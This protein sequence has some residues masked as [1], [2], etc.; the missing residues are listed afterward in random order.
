MPGVW[1]RVKNKRQTKEICL[2]R[3]PLTHVVALC[4]FFFF[5]SS[6]SPVSEALGED[7]SP[8]MVNEVRV[9]I[10]TYLFSHMPSYREQIAQL[11]M[12]SF[13][14]AR[15][16][17]SILSIFASLYL[18]SSMIPY[19]FKF[20]YQEEASSSPVYPCPKV[21]TLLRIWE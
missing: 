20:C 16:P 13:S 6:F 2:S 8:G 19:I 4:N 11:Y 14:G 21:L 1:K 15:P 7:I 3:P 9:Q 10:P 5:L 17:V 18:S 12:K